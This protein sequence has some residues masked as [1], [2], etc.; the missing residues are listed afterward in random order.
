[1]QMQ[2]YANVN[3]GEVCMSRLSCNDIT[4]FRVEIRT[5]ARNDG[6]TSCDG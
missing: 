4:F 5:G 6:S 1:M 2:M 3:V